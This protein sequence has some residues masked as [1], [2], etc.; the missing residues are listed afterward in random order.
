M[1]AKSIAPASPDRTIIIVKDG[2]G[3]EFRVWNRF[4]G[5]SAIGP[6]L[7]RKEPLPNL[8]TKTATYQ[9]AIDL[10]NKWQAWLDSQPNHGR[11]KGKRT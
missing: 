6:R 3:F 10:Q 8:P 11:R 7:S 5:D 4:L 1:S 9:T 2:D